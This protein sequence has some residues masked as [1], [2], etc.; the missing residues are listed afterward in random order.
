L[1]Q[2]YQVNHVT[3]PKSEYNMGS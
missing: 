2:A 3:K 1:L